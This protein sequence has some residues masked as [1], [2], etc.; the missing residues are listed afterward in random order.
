M[1]KLTIT[2]FS[3]LLSLHLLAAY[4]VA[5]NG[6]TGNPWCNGKSWVVNGSPMTDQG[7]GTWSVTFQ[8]VPAGSYE[9]KVTNG[10]S[11]WYG[12]NKFSADCSNLYA[13]G[14]D[15]IAFSITATQDITITYNGSKICLTGSVGNDAPDPDQFAKV[16]VPSEY[17]GVMLQAFYWD[18]HKLTTFSRTKY[19]D[20]LN[21]GLADEMGRN[22]DL[23][24]FPPSGNGGGVGYYTKCYSN[25]DSDWGT[26]AKLQEL[27][28]KLHGYDCKVIADIVINHMQSNSGWAKSFATNNFGSYGT[29]T[30]SS[31]HICSGD[32]AFTSSSSDSKSLPHGNADTGT[33]DGGCRDLDHTSSYVQDMCKAYTS[34]MKNVIGFD[35]FRYDMTLGYNGQYLSMYNLASEPFFSVSECWTDLNKIKSHL[36]AAS[37]NT[38][39]F[40]FP[41][42]YKMNSWKGGSSYTYLRNPGLRS[43]GL[44]KFAVTFID[45]HDTFH[46]SDNQSGEFLGYNTDLSAKR[47]K[48]IEA[49]AY[50]LMM[51][52]VPCVFWP[53]WYVCRDEINQL[54]AIRKQAGIHSES[55][56]SDE[57]AGA[58]YYYATITGHRGRVIL[59]MGSKRDTDTPA[60]YTRAYA[61]ANFDIYTIQGTDVD[62]ISIVNRPLKVME[63]GQIYIL[64]N[65]VRYTIDG[66]VAE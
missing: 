5:G 17:E 13:S 40:D 16:G 28:N 34:W 7:N 30:L 51:P 60:G 46:R 65:G 42:K 23:V 47:D 56:V 45:N 8:S 48:I 29:Y 54:I 10:I 43:L 53:H 36:E 66:C 20:F 52:G 21:S 19:I 44:S 58:N 12:V 24:W 32:E 62:N 63:N 31:Q 59:R 25:L 61:G 50:L 18:S 33:N 9:F 1:K 41:A 39:A 3:L 2:I 38:L 55:N 26:K 49:N 27:I 6:T 57:T 4:Y 11:T 64:R 35:G 37:Y 22:F 15:N 14:G